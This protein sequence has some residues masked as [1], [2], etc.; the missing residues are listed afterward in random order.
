MVGGGRAA[1]GEEG[2]G[3][4]YLASGVIREQPA[5]QNCP[6]GK[7]GGGVYIRGVHLND[8]AIGVH[9][10]VVMLDF[11]LAVNLDSHGATF[12]PQSNMR[13]TSLWCCTV[14][15]AHKGSAATATGLGPCLVADLKSVHLSHRLFGHM[16]R[17]LNIDKK[18]KL[19]IQFS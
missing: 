5:N 4:P 18:N 7:G 16:Y 19:I 15:K 6:F 10:I 9:V 14:A 17:L 12:V 13:K 11:D 3:S 2:S 1:A 8:Y